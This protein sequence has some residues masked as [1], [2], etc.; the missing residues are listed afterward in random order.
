MYIPPAFRDD[1]LT[2]IHQTIRE[3]GLATLVTAAEG[4]LTGT[5]LP[6]F[7][8][9]SEGEKGTLYAHLARANPQW[10]VAPSGEAMA[11]FMG[12]DAYITPSWYATKQ[13]TGK[14]VPTWD[15]VAVHA[16]GLVEF[17]E[18]AD[19]LLDVITRLT[20]LHE[21]TRAEPWAVSDAPADYIKA[22]L[23]GI[24]GVRMPITK[25]EG[26]R[27]LSQNYSAADRAG[28]I[29]GLSRSGNAQEA[30]VAALLPR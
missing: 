25:L 4:G 7:L 17:F 26:K 16:Y 12:P 30:A 29:E 3:S 1:D 27:K 14:V 11:I 22:Q 23:R 9:T 28:V 19:S 10:K 13:Q 5:P 8:D 20:N 15:Y 18:D 21:Q 2:R 6:M 24:V